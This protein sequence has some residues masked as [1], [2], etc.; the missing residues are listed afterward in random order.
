MLST[1]L[2]ASLRQM[3]ATFPLTTDE[4]RNLNDAAKMIDC[5][6][7]HVEERKSRAKALRL[8]ERKGDIHAALLDGKI[9]VLEED[10]RCMTQILEGK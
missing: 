6:A 10:S 1:E 3:A 4:M 5:F 7:E 2:S 9:S 8:I